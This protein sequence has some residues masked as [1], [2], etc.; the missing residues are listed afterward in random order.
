MNTL[1]KLKEK[2]CI[3]TVPS[4][5]L[6]KEIQDIILD[7]KRL[8]KPLKSERLVKALTSFVSEQKGAL[9]YIVLGCTDLPSLLM[10]NGVCMNE[11]DG[12]ALIDPIDS[13]L[14]LCEPFIPQ[15]LVNSACQDRVG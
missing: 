10:T 9:D 8:I 6:Q 2:V 7:S 1:Y 13:L 11:I 5:E 3:S 14:E 15:C 12:V 4:E